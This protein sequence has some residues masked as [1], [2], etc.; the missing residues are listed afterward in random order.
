MYA[1]TSINGEWCCNQ[2]QL[3]LLAYGYLLNH[4]RFTQIRN[5]VLLQKIVGRGQKGKVGKDSGS[6]KI[7]TK[8]RRLRI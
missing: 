1:V 3:K 4:F 5:L 7:K 2:D 8:K 6:N